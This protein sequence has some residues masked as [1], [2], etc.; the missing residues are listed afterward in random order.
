MDRIFSSL[1]FK[2]VKLANYKGSPETA[3]KQ[4]EEERNAEGK[5]IQEADSRFSARWKK[6]KAA[7]ARFTAA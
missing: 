2:R 4:M 1:Y 5:R 7:A 3:L 6:E